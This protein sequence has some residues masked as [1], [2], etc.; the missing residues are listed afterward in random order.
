MKI[1]YNIEFGGGNFEKSSSICKQLGDITGDDE[2]K[3]EA[4]LGIFKADGDVELTLEEM[5]AMFKNHRE[6]IADLRDFL[7]MELPTLING[8][9]TAIADA[10]TAISISEHH[11]GLRDIGLNEKRAEL[12]KKYYEE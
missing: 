12:R 6:N 8:V 1:R 3:I 5:A 10:H 4:N 2:S 9:G 11:S 7:K